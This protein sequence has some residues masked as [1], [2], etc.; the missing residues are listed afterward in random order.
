MTTY[1]VS[2]A[3][4]GRVAGSLCRSL[5]HAGNR[6][7]QIVSPDMKE[8]RLLAQEC[9]AS[10][11]SDLVFD[12]SDDV[13]IIAVPDQKLIEVLSA[14]NCHEDCVVAHT[15]GSYGLDVFPERLKKKGVFYPLQT[16]SK[17]RETETRD[18]PFIIEASQPGTEAILKG[19]AVSV[20]GKPY[21]IDH[22]TRR[23]LHLAAVFVNNFSNFMLTAGKEVV[24]KA[25]LSFD[26]LFPLIK[27]TFAKALEKGPEY[28]QTG[29]ALRKDRNTI[30][31]HLE[32]LSFS[33]E[34]QHIYREL[35]ESIITYYH[36][37]N[38]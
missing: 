8:G 27:E 29:P 16:F 32:L 4:A 12:G 18:L 7:N 11:S 13:I 35:T 9:Q 38:I 6:I 19:L 23:M 26:I 24:I 36:N 2:F 21:F 10:W 30:E 28:S 17:G 3:G 37:R 22:E 15:A 33:P 31:K 1:N 25:G 20:G 34:L 14:I 5:Y